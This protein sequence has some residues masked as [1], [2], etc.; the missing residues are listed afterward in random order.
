M[1]LKDLNKEQKHELREK[2]L[3]DRDERVTLG[4]LLDAD[5]LVSDE[6]LEAEFGGISFVPD[7]F[8]CSA[9]A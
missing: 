8:F 3:C 2:I 4:E 6:E 5:A 9:V 7:D 1:Y